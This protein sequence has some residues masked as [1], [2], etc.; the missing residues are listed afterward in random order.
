MK[1]ED[2]ITKTECKVICEILGIP[3]KLKQLEPLLLCMNNCPHCGKSWSVLR[4]EYKKVAV[5]EY[6][7]TFSGW[8][9][10]TG[11][12]VDSHPL[13]QVL[14]AQVDAAV[15]RFEVKRGKG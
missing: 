2:M 13:Q 1:G 12:S 3:E 4:A 7:L 5:Y 15:E 10:H 11:H 8:L 14:K 9:T 6:P